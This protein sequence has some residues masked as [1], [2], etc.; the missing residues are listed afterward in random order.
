MEDP[1][2]MVTLEIATAL[3]RGIPVIPVLVQEARMPRGTAL[4]RD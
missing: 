3:D 2:D 4:P 1:D